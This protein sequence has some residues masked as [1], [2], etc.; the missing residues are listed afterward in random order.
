MRAEP[1]ALSLPK[2]RRRASLRRAKVSSL[3]LRIELS[4]SRFLGPMR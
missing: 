4:E 2:S 1:P 3:N